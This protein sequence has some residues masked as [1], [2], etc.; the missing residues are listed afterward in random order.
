MTHEPT[1]AEPRVADVRITAASPEVAGY[2]A[3]M[4]RAWFAGT[5]QHGCPAGAEGTGT[6]LHLRVDTIRPA[7][8]DP[9]PEPAPDGPFEEGAQQIWP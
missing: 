3:Q 6:A 5:E 8:S 4:P 2:V 1:L 9:A 7:L